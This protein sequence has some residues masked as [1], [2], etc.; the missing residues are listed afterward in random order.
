MY[1]TTEQREKIKEALTKK[2]TAKV[3]NMYAPDGSKKVWICPACKQ[4][5]KRLNHIMGICQTTRCLG[6]VPDRTYQELHTHLQRKAETLILDCRKGNKQKVR[7]Y[8]T[9]GSGKT[10]GKTRIQKTG[11]AAVE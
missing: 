3:N 8:W 1:G 9:D 5:G 6:V 7:T 4:Q 2:N 10:I 11:W